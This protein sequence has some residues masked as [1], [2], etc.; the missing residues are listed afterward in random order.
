MFNLFSSRLAFLDNL[1]ALLHRNNNGKDGNALSI[2]IDAGWGY[3]K[4]FF[5]NSLGEKLKEE[6][7]IVVPF[8][9]WESDISEDAFI[10][11]ADALITKLVD[12]V[13]PENFKNEFL[14][15]ANSSIMTFGKMLF[16]L[17]LLRTVFSMLFST[18]QKIQVVNSRSKRLR[19]KGSL[20]LA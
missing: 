4:T 7:S 3:G 9:A 14:R 17:Q 11:F 16:F 5:M 12:Y 13:E 2:S 6:G 10:A 20:H 18:L 15:L 1:C 8:N 19:K